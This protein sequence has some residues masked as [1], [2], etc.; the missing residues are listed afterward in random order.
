MK[1]INQWL[2]KSSYIE[3]LPP[4]CKMCAEGCKMVVLIT[5]L[6]PSNCYYCPLS[7]E[8]IGKDRVFADEWEL[9]DEDE[10]EILIREAELIDACGAGITGG[11]PLMVPERTIRYIRILKESFGSNF[12]IHLYTSGLKN[13]ETVKKI[14][15]VGLDE[16]RFH[17][18]PVFWSK[19]ND[20]LVSK[21]IEKVLGYDLDVAL[22]I[23]VIPG[24]GKE[25]FSLIEWASTKNLVWV[26][27][28]E[29]EFSET[30]QQ[31]LVDR[32]FES[33]NDFSSHVRGSE[34]C[35]Y[36]V[37]EKCSKRELDIGVHYCSCS[38]KD[39]VQLRSRIKRRAENIV[40]SYE[41][42]SDD[43]TLL[44]GIVDKKG[45][46]NEEIKDFLIKEFGIESDFVF[47]NDSKKRVEIALWILE[48][49]SETLKNNGFNCYMIEEYPTADRLE[50]ERTS[51][52]L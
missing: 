47:V 45:F 38:F 7:S 36:D 39:A 35:A 14:V 19:M 28:N 11:D 15:D 20:S 37:L 8:K 50:V 41:I 52:P 34:K 23:P 25:I 48:K 3:P 31:K 30:N 24:M 26:N 12:H 33:E 9:K 27:L 5:G 1:Q 43:G 17:P 51:L 16:I 49:L 21:N 18:A 22:E 2:K 13:I 44:L 40:K 42:I 6:C 32:G 10:T 4:A 46:S 29:L